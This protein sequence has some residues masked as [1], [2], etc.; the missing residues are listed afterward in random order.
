MGLIS[1]SISYIRYKTA[2]DVS[3]DIRQFALEKLK[4]YS[5]REIDPASLTEKSLGWVSTENM[6]STF[7][8]NLHFLKAPYLVFSLRIDERRIPSLTMKAAFLREEIKYKKATG[9][10]RLYKKDKDMLKEEVRQNLLKK[11]LPVPSLYDVCW[12]TSTGIVLLCAGSKKAHEEF[13]NF[14][15]QSFEIK[16]LPLV[17]YDQ[18]AAPVPDNKNIIIKDLAGNVPSR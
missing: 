1:G 9:K 3:E 7:F 18:D 4:K 10:E 15:F 16:L 5:F 11:M 17:Y 8:D 6:A 14:F 2:G 13:V 12:N